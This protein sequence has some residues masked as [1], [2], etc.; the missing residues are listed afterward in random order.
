MFFDSSEKLRLGYT[1][2]INYRN[3]SYNEINLAEPISK[4]LYDQNIKYTFANIDN[5]ANFNYI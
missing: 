5:H 3:S 2:Y 1:Q 4:A